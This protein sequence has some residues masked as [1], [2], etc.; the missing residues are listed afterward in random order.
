MVFGAWIFIITSRSIF[1]GE[2]NELGAKV[3]FI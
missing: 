2:K 1:V 3:E